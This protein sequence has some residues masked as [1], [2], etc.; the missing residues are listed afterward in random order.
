MASNI[1]VFEKSLLESKA[2]YKLSGNQIRILNRFMMKRKLKKIKVKGRKAE[3]IITNNGE[4]VFT[5]SEAEK[6]GMS[7]ST[8]LRAIDRLVEVGLIDITHSGNGNFKGD[9]SKYFISDR[10]M[11]YGMK[12]FKKKTRLKD[13][14]LRNRGVIRKQKEQKKDAEDFSGKSKIEL[15]I[16]VKKDASILSE[17]PVLKLSSKHQE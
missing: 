11:E 14:R 3:W 10:W 13:I 15:K 5:Y 6:M 9:C 2:Y 7:R 8:F 4:I 12:H 17:R 1:I 16:S